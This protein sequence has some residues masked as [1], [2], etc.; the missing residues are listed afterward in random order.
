MI[1]VLDTPPC[2]LSQID[3]TIEGDGR[4]LVREM[5]GFHPAICYHDYLREAGYALK[6]TGSAW[7]KLRASRPRRPA[8]LLTPAQRRTWR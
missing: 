4:R 1:R 8:A 2:Q 3:V 6:R 5:P 7:D